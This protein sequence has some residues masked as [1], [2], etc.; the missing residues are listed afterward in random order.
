MQSRSG[1]RSRMWWI[2]LKLEATSAPNVKQWN[3]KEYLSP[4]IQETI[5]HL[6]IVKKE[7]DQHGRNIQTSFPSLLLSKF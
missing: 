2:F 4:F 1:P 5:A 7:T 3:Q 6:T